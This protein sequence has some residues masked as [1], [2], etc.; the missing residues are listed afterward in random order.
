MYPSRIKLDAKKKI[1]LFEDA[2]VD[3]GK[4]VLYWFDKLTYA[5][6]PSVTGSYYDGDL[7]SWKKE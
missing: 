3:L 2:L 7:L 1:R 4:G 5:C 6:P